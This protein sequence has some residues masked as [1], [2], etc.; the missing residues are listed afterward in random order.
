MITVGFEKKK[1]KD[2]PLGKPGV[3]ID[4]S[5]IKPFIGDGKPKKAGKKDNFY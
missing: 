4:P 1:V 2:Q 3:F 5:K